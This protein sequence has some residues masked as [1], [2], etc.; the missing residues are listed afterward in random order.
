MFAAHPFA[1][2]ALDTAESS[3][4]T[5][6]IR[7]AIGVDELTIE[8]GLGN[9][10]TIVVTYDGRRIDHERDDVAI[11]RF[12]EERHDAVIGVVKI[13]PIESFICIV[14]LPKRGFVFVDVIQ[15]L[16]QPSQAIV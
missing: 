3:Y 15:M 5:P 4:I 8:A 14:E 6:A 1:S 16:H 9:A 13:D 12:S 7:F 10:Q 2:F 11:A